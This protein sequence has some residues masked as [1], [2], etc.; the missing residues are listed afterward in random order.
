MNGILVV[1]KPLGWT[2]HEVVKK[3]KKHF[4]L[5]K[6]G[7]AGTLD[8]NATGVLVL[9]INA[10]TRFVRFFPCEPKEYEGEMILGIRTDTLDI[11]GQI[12]AKEL[13]NITL[14]KVRKVSNRFLGYVNQVPP[15]VSAVKVDGTPLYVLA[16]EGKAVERRPRKVA[17]I[18]LEI[19]KLVGNAHQKVLFR[20]LCSKGTY[21]RSFCDDMGKYLGCGACLGNLVRLRSGEFTLDKAWKVDEILGLKAN[22]L[23]KILI[24]LAQALNRY[25]AITVKES[26]KSRVLN[27]GF[28]AHD[29]IDFEEGTIGKKEIVR[30]LDSRE[31]LLGLA[32]AQTKFSAKMPLSPKETILRPICIIPNAKGKTKNEK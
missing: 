32:K 5:A 19:L 4:K 14:D 27:G 11:T 24:P 15:M 30:I 21:I 17:I 25:N 2:S 16:R 28:L 22:R 13:S 7:H 9:C 26:F 1:D 12:V 6:V 18:K 20:V 23:E 10:A 3:I 31:N 29:M 8:P